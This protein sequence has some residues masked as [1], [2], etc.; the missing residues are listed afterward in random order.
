MGGGRTSQTSSQLGQ[1]M[2]TKSLGVWRREQMRQARRLAWRVPFG[3]IVEGWGWEWVAREREGSGR[4]DESERCNCGCRSSS[5]IRA[6]RDC[7]GGNSTPTGR[8]V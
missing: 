6:I 4:V 7:L 1:P 5:S 8:G 2:S 3:G